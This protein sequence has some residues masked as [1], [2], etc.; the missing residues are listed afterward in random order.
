[1]AGR[2]YEGEVTFERLSPWSHI[3]VSKDILSILSGRTLRPV[4]DLTGFFSFV[5]LKAY[6]EFLTPFPMKIA[7]IQQHATEDKQKNIDLGLKHLE[8]AARKDA[9]LAAYAELAFTRFYPQHHGGGDI[10]DLAETVPGPTTDAFAA[11][12]KEL[13][14]AVIINLFERDGARTYDSSPV[15]DSD[16][17]LLGVTR[18]THIAD[19]ACFYEKDYYTPGDSGA[20]VYDTSVGRWGWLFATTA[21]ILSTCVP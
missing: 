21:T 9:E 16:G 14:M 17:T 20:S 2:G 5:S 1:M 3:L 4:K 19:Y 8:E 6:V 13:G 15:V 18:M 12:A 10:L 11:K 7:L